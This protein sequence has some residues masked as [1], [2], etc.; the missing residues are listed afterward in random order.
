[1]IF[2]AMMDKRK[3]VVLRNNCTHL[4]SWHIGLVVVCIILYP[5]AK[6]VLSKTLFTWHTTARRI[7]NFL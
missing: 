7:Y 1:M 5:G 6:I 3:G 2:K 4:L